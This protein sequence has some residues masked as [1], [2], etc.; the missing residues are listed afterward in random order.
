MP[1]FCETS[2]RHQRHKLMKLSLAQY[3]FVVL[4][5]CWLTH[6]YIQIIASVKI[7]IAAVECFPLQFPFPLIH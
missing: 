7:K 2:T 4:V 1:Q 5:A 6:H 3:S